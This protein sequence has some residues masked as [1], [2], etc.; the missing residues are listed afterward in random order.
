MHITAQFTQ[1]Y[2]DY[3]KEKHYKNPIL[4]YRYYFSTSY[5]KKSHL[6]QVDHS[7]NV[8]LANLCP[9]M[10]TN[11]YSKY[12]LKFIDMLIYMLTSSNVM[13]ES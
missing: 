13:Q 8:I 12:I 9:V 3:E 6:T 11:A 10:Y 5:K 4:T 7:V 2:K 1:Q